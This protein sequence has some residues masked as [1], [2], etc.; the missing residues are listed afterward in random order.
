MVYCFVFNENS[1]LSIKSYS[2]GSS[3]GLKLKLYSNFYKKLSLFNSNYGGLGLILKVNNNTY[4]TGDTVEVKV[5][6]GFESDVVIVRLFKNK[7]PKNKINQ[8]S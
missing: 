8:Q 4:L 5:P 7:M 3:G 2:T 6:S 1:S